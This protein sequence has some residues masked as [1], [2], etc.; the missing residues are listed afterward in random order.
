MNKNILITGGAGF[1]GSHLCSKAIEAG[2]NV[3]CLDNLSTGCF[4]NIEHL[5]KFNSFR[6]IEHDVVNEY[7][8]QVDQIYNLA[9]YAS[10][11]SYLEN[12]IKTIQTLVQ[13]TFNTLN[14]AKK[15][16]AKVVHASTSEIYGAPLVHPQPECYFG[17][18][19]TQSIKSCY[20]EGKRI[21]ETICYE[22][23][24]N[25]SVNISIA[26]IFN[27]Y[28]PRMK[29][30]DGRVISNFIFQALHNQNISVY[31]SGKQTRS[32]CYID[33]LVDGLTTL[34]HNQSPT[35]IFNLGNPEEVSILDLA[36]LIKKMTQSKSQIIFNENG[37][38]DL[39]KRCPDIS[40]AK[41]VLKWEPKQKLI[42]G[43]NKTIQYYINTF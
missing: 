10:P 28:G 25:Y 12:S 35:K 13:G 9:S 33:D 34:M 22:F 14:I 40:L 30:N 37:Y 19:D 42:S 8:F 2:N 1:I 41:S 26:R 16:N 11:K 43:L 38:S 15:Y 3:I 5:T 7:D 17:N 27:T 32:F 18:V 24:K 4:S 39:I 29:Q 21:S 6:F 20:S 31:G 36:K 23:T